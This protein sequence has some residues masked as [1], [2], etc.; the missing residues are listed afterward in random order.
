MSFVNAWLSYEW[1]VVAVWQLQ[2]LRLVPLL[3]KTE[4]IEKTELN[5]NF[6]GSGIL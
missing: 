3:M 4:V 1:A 5:V 2:N 6:C